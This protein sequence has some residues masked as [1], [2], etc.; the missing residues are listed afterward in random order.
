MCL[1]LAT[2]EQRKGHAFLFEAFRRVQESFPQV[3]LV[4]CGDGTEAERNQVLNLRSSIA[5]DANIHLLE[6]IPEGSNL[7]RQADLLVV[8]SQEWESF[9]W[10]VIEAMARGVPVVS[11]NAGGLAEVIG[12]DGVAGFAVDPQDVERFA[13]CIGELISQ[14]NRRAEMGGAGRRRVAE[15]FS[16]ERMAAEYAKIIRRP[17]VEN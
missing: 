14:P 9:G 15:H 3:H 7:I 2:Y 1:M 16:V 8:A 13:A 6:Y 11:T 5:P 12:P 17:C 4:I 10:T